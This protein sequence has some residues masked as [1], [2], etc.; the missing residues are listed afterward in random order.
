[1]SGASPSGSATIQLW[2]APSYPYSA[3]PAWQR[4]GCRPKECRD[5][6]TKVQGTDQRHTLDLQ[7]PSPISWP[8]AMGATSGDLG[9][10]DT[11]HLE[12][13]HR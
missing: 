6:V 13:T 3:G 9:A 4:V 1:M 11:V 8:P 10:G 7:V 5:V 2:E 12:G